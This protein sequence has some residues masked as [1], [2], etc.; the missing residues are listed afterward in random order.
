LSDVL[1]VIETHLNNV[2]SMKEG[3]KKD[4]EKLFEKLNVKNMIDDPSNT[5]D[6]L[7]FAITERMVKKYL[8]PTIKESQRYATSVL[9][10]KEKL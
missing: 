3:I 10:S 1:P 5:I 7:I 9:S 2:D 8:K 6:A 4:I